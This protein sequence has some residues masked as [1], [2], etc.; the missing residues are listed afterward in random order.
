[1]STPAYETFDAHLHVVDFLQESDGLRA[2]L[3]RMDEARVERAVIFGMPVTKEW[4][5]WEPQGPDYYLAD[6]A[7]LYPYSLTDA[8][9]AERYLALSA[10]ERARFIPLLCGF[11]P[12]DKYAL[13]HVQRL[14]K[15][16]PG[17][18]RG[19][20]ELLLRH[21]D[22]TNLL[23]GQPPRA[24]H[25]ALHGVYALAG[26]RGLPVL[27]HQDITAI[28]RE[29]PLYEGELIGAL[30][31]HPETTFVWA[32]LGF[33]R[34]VRLPDHAAYVAGLLERFPN[35][36]GDLSWLVFDTLV[37]PGGVPDDAWLALTERYS[38]RLCLGSDLS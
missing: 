17:V 28:G 35:L 18:F 2:L 15:L 11:N 36:Y 24:N 31:E 6:N 23:Y 32:H 7:R 33:S 10:E 20:G 9:V 22:L 12:V 27:V 13:K 8:L 37:C 16:Y 19:I 26:E 1:M 14:I 30:A 3:T 38:D 4:A 21:D 34:R 5:E 25:P 29:V